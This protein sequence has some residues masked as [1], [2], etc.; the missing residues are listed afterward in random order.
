MNSFSLIRRETTQLLSDRSRLKIHFK[1]VLGQFSRDSR[2]VRRLPCEYILIILQEPDERTFLFV[3]EAGADDASFAFIRES[4]I[5]PFSFFTQP[6]R[7]RSLSFI[8]GDREIFILQSVVRLCGKGYRGPDSESYLDG[9][10]KAFRGALE[11]GMHGDNPLRSRHLKYHVRVV[12]NS[13]EFR[14]SWSSNDGVV[15]TVEACHLEPQELGSIVLWG[16]KGDGQVDV[17]E[18]VIPFGRHDAEEG[19]IQL[20]GVFDGNPQGLERLGEGDVDAAS[21]S[22]NTFFTRLSQTTGSTSSGYLLG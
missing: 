21:P 3:V 11:V 22:T 13:H 14:K 2:H 12:W 20:I 15:P 6:N 1:F 17:T 10:L 16:S 7:G 5:N 4:Q 19:S 8:R 9:A 18:R